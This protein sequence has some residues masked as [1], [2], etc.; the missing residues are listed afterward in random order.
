[1]KQSK[2]QEFDPH[3]SE[4]SYIV[5]RDLVK[6]HDPLVMSRNAQCPYDVEKKT[7]DVQV[8]GEDYT[9]QYPSGE[10]K[11]SKGEDFDNYSAKIIILRYLMNAKE[12]SD[13]GEMISFKEFPDGP[14]YYSN[15]YKRCIQ[16]FANIGNEMPEALKKYMA[17][18]NASSWEKGD[19]SWQFTFMPG[20]RVTCVLW[21]SDDEFEAEAQI[22]FD[23]RLIKVFNIK[24]L[25]ILGDV[26]IISLKTFTFSL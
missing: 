2:I 16:V 3:F 9:V 25:A 20:V 18:I 15:F 17:S 7:F 13:A 8:L 6:N 24:D 26:F 5:S 1:M 14:L 4:A 10:V 12:T 19:Q 23:K 11:N 21:F 22:L